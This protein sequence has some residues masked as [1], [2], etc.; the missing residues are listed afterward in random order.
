MGGT[1]VGTITSISGGLTTGSL[2]LRM[3]ML[4]VARM[5][6]TVKTGTATGGTVNSLVDENSELVP[7]KYNGGTLWMLSGDN[8]DLCEI[9][10]DSA[11]MT[12]T[13][14]DNLA[15]PI[16]AGDMYAVALPKFSKMDL[17]QAI[18][19][20]LAHTQI[21]RVNLALSVAN[22]DTYNLPSG[23]K[24]VKKLFIAGNTS[25]PYQWQENHYWDEINGQLV[26]LPG[27]Y[28]T[29]IG[30]PMKL[31]Y[32]GNHGEIYE[33][34]DDPAQQSNEIDASLNQDYILWSAVVFLWRMQVQKM[35]KDDPYA[36]DFLNEAK[37]EMDREKALGKSVTITKSVRYTGF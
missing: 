11:N 15:L 34:A 31:V 10:K 21:I 14:D 12:F 25:D 13:L 30:K 27:K 7:G 23:V 3:A 1:G 24:N 9:I 5:M 26:F 8:V 19:F 2:T 4:E 6:G 36:I 33:L 17:K 35:G 28:P 29:D 37:A 18:N 20:V 32:M 16:E 22:S